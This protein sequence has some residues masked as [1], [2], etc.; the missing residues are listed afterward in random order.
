MKPIEATIAH[1]FFVIIASSLKELYKYNGMCE[2]KFYAKLMGVALVKVC[3]GY[4]TQYVHRSLE[5]LII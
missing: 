2:T 4:Y 3:D 5:L 1:S